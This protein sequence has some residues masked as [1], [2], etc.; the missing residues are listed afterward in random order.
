MSGGNPREPG[1]TYADDDGDGLSNAFEESRGTDTQS[2]DT[3]S[4]GLNDA[5]EQALGSS[6]TV[7]D[8]DGDGILDGAEVHL[9]ESDPTR[10][11]SKRKS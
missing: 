6:S 11:A 5:E 10:G 1:D 2:K 4:D 7:C 3:D 9:F 8:T